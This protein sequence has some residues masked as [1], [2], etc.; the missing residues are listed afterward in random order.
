MTRHSLWDWVRDAPCE[1]A[2][3]KTITA[4]TWKSRPFC[5][6]PTGAGDLRTYALGSNS[7]ARATVIA[8]AR[9]LS[10]P[11]L[12]AFPTRTDSTKSNQRAAESPTRD[13]VEDEIDASGAQIR[14][15]RI[16]ARRVRE[17]ETCTEHRDSDRITWEIQQT[18]IPTQSQATETTEAQRNLRFGIWDLGFANG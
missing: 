14:V 10:D 12:S 13:L 18:Q 9:F 3:R 16:D 11:G 5:R 7:D 4:S 1:K 6:A 17:H 8:T 15:A 2:R